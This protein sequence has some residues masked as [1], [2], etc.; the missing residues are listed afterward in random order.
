MEDRLVQILHANYGNTASAPVYIQSFEVGNL[1]YINGLTDIRIV[2]LLDAGGMPYDFTVSGDLRTYADL[3]K[4]DANGLQFIDAYAD[5][6]SVDTSLMI[7]LVSGMLGTPTTLV[8]DV[9][10]LG[11]EV[12]AWTFRAEN[13][14]LPNEFDSSTN[15][16]EFGDLKGQILAF[17]R[18]GMDGFFTD[19]PDLG[20][21]A[22]LSPK[23]MPDRK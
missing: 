18:L 20:V 3:A 13:L 1:Q 17:T 23:P 12:H 14:F 5:G 11:M 9:H 10:S 8:A 21:A 16:A 4:L 15:P 7:P 22:I 6:V 2:Q 19:Q